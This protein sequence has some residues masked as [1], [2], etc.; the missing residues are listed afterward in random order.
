M[1]AAILRS[2]GR[3]VVYNEGLQRDRGRHHPGP[4]P[5]HPHR[6]GESR[7]AAH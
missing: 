3:R 7:R 4:D 1:I 5:R 6:P 2:D